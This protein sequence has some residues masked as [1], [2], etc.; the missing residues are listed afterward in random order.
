MVYIGLM[1]G[2]SLIYI[3]VY[4]YSIYLIYYAIYSPC[5]GGCSQIRQPIPY[6]WRQATIDEWNRN[7]N[8]VEPIMKAQ[9]VRT[10][11]YCASP[12]F[13]LRWDHCDCGNRFERRI[14]HGGILEL[15]LVH[16]PCKYVVYIIH[17]I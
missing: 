11:P 13:D 10:G 8:S 4:L 15:L 9:C 16:D 2:V 17:H 7:I 6:G 5:S 3:S 14:N 12:Y 1:S